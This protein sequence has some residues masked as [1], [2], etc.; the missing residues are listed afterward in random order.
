MTVLNIYCD[1]VSIHDSNN[2]IILGALFIEDIDVK[3]VIDHLENNRC[4]N[5]SNHK[6]NYEYEACPNKKIC[7]EDLH[8]RNNTVIH[9]KEIDKSRERK[10]IAQ[11]W[12]ILL[13]NSL[14]EYVKFSILIIDLNKL[15]RDYF[16]QRKTDLN[17][18]NRFFRTLLKGGIRYLYQY[19]HIQIKNVYHDQG[20]QENHFYFPELNLEKLER[21]TSDNFIIEDKKIKFVNDDHRIYL[22]N[23]DMDLVIN[24]HF[25]Q[26]IDLILGSFTQLYLNLS[27]NDDKKEVAEVIRELFES[28]FK[29]ERKYSGSVSFFPRYSLSELVKIERYSINDFNKKSY[30]DQ[31]AIALKFQGNFY[32]TCTFAMPKFLKNQSKLSAWM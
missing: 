1:E 6:W 30:E 13:K 24:S 29:Y 10:N 2:F 12:L 14:K 15:D 11:K 20:S 27:S 8:K 16:G 31:I 23:N 9:F 5:Q 3:R 26:L 28:I 19:K 4:L 21:N 25:I 17:I 18:Y 7:K 32:N 22:K